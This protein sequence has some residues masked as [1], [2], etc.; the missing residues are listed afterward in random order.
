MPGLLGQ[1]QLQL[2]GQRLR[3]RPGVFAEGSQGAGRTAELQAQ[4]A[5]LEFTQALAAAVEC[6]QPARD[7]HAQGH[8]RCVLQPGTPG[9][10]CGLV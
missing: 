8:R 10:R 4:Q 1:G 5:R 9:Q 7:F 3:H 6:A 2:A